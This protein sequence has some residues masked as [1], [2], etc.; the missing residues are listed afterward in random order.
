V[1]IL[2]TSLL[3]LT[4][5]EVLQR[6]PPSIEFIGSLAAGLFGAFVCSRKRILS[7]IA[8]AAIGALLFFATALCLFWWLGM[9][10]A[11]APV[12]LIFPGFLGLRLLERAPASAV[13]PRQQGAEIPDHVMQRHIGAGSFGDVWLATNAV[14][15]PHA[16]KIVRRDRFDSEIPYEREFQGIKHFMPI[17]AAH[18]G[19]VRIHHVGRD[20][21]QRYFFYIMEAADDASTGRDI[22]PPRYSPKSLAG[23][24]TARG[25]LPALECLALALD[26]SG[27][28]QCLHSKG[29]VHRDI[30]PANVIYVEGRPKLADIGLVAEISP[31][32]RAPTLVGTPGYLLVE[33][34]GT[35]K[36]DLYAFGKLLYAALTGLDARQFPELPTSISDGEYG[37][38]TAALNEIAWKLCGLETGGFTNAEEVRQALLPLQKA[39]R[40]L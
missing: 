26:L 11:W 10:F 2:A 22:E 19:F 34:A 3:N 23:E 25:R 29:L 12:L 40:A 6:V 5:D 21:E 1:E 31:G 4:R 16:V 14:G 39:A 15:I 9:W 36:N 33:A 17:S 28:L 7:A 18:S 8:S 37:A 20:D 38:L 24:I 32:L 13:A 35:I 27:A 30:K